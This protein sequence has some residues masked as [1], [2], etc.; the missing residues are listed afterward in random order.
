[1]E[2]S[3]LKRIVAGR[4]DYFDLVD[5]RKKGKR[6]VKN[7]SKWGYKEVAVCQCL[8]FLF[9]SFICRMFAS[10]IEHQA[11]SPLMEI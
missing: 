10:A 7:D 6:K 4:G 8:R 11:V 3:G 5:G 2:G 1:M 9:R